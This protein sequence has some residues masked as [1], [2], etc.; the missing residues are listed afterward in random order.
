[1][2]Q[3]HQSKRIQCAAPGKPKAIATKAMA[4]N[5]FIQK[6]V[7]VLAKGQ[8]PPIPRKRV[9]KEE[10]KAPRARKARTEAEAS[11][12]PE[13]HLWIRGDLALARALVLARG[14]VLAL[15][16]ASPALQ[17]TPNLPAEIG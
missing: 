11:R 1:M 10:A 14:L 13:T 8:G 5:G 15:D 2:E 3:L 4:V 12:S 16:R 17:P 7:V 6:K 9:A